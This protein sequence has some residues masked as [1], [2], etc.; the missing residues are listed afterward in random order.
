MYFSYVSKHLCS[1]RSFFPVQIVQW[2]QNQNLLRLSDF[3]FFDPLSHAWG[4]HDERGEVEET[5]AF[6]R[7]VMIQNILIKLINY[8]FFRTKFDAQ[9]MLLCNFKTGVVAI[10]HSKC[11]NAYALFPTHTREHFAKY[12][13][14]CAEVSACFPYMVLTKF[15]KRVDFTNFRNRTIFRYR[16]TSKGVAHLLTRH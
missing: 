15:D 13:R 3:Y 1:I 14:Q 6:K 2:I 11:A 8:F 7:T 12:S 4:V 10:P 5:H 16:R 9:I